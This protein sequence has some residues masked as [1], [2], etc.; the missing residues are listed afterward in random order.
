MILWPLMMIFDL[1]LLAGRFELIFAVQAPSGEFY[2]DHIDNI[3]FIDDHKVIKIDPFGRS[4]E[5]GSLSSGSVSSV[6]VS[7]PFQILVFYRDFNRILFLD[8]R[9]STLRS[10]IN[11]SDLGIDRA[12]LACSSGMGGFWIYSDHDNRLV[13][14]GQQLQKSHTS[15][16]ISSITGTNVKPVY[17]TESRNLIYLHVP[18]DGILLFDRYASYVRTIPYSGPDRFRVTAGKVIYFDKGSLLAMDIASGEI[19]SIS[20]PAGVLPDNADIR[21]ERIYILAGR[22]IYAYSH[23]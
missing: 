15:M 22:M 19:S 13:Y 21:P 16:M 7:N 6:D 2:T 4:F 11:I 20:V 9:L 18:G 5:Y 8:N 10:G 23:R 17:M 14:F 1:I 12:I 3:Y